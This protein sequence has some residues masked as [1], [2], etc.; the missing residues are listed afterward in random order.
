MT[1]EI[2]PA[3]QWVSYL[4]GSEWP[5]GDESAMFRLGSDWHDAA[6]QL[7]DLIPDLAKV[8]AEV[9]TVLTGA[10]AK[11]A[12]EQFAMLFD[13]D[14]AVDKLADAMSALG[15]L[16][17]STGSQIEY[18]KLQIISTLAISAAEI[19]YALAMAPW[20]F[21][22]SLSWIPVIEAATWVAVRAAAA[23]LRDR[24]ISATTAVLTRTVV[25]ELSA[26]AIK[27][28]IVNIV[29]D[30]AVQQFVK[31]ALHEAAEET[32]TSTAQEFAIEGIQNGEGH[33]HGFDVKQIVSGG[34]SSALGGAAGAGAHH[35]I[36]GV[37]GDAT[38]VVGKITQGA[39]THFGVGIVG[40]VAGSVTGGGLDSISVFGGAAGGALSGGIHGS[41]GHGESHPEPKEADDSAPVPDPPPPYSDPPPPYPGP[42]GS[43]DVSSSQPPPEGADPQTGAGGDSAA[44]QQLTNTDQPASGGSAAP[45][46]TPDNGG[47]SSVNNGAAGT[48]G[49]SVD[50]GAASVNNGGAGNGAAGNGASVNNGPTGNGAASVNN[51]GAAAVRRQRCASVNNGAAGNGAAPVTV[52]PV[53]VRHR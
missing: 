31:N 8:R 9:A 21:G 24:I 47:A 43:T 14:F 22:E 7:S 5:K 27:Q 53:T 11:A 48:G 50:N 52:P 32:V 18:S 30:P 26:K 3:L 6:T 1:I 41:G 46:P 23:A 2:P 44:P 36:S 16:A 40:N 12:Q 13:G 33:H 19:S 25:K 35:Q 10:T 15:D 20:T 49:A 17:N 42:P 28:T 45:S 4:A 29:K 51:G 39:A 34:Y 38:S 37:L